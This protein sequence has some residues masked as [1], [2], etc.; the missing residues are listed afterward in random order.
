LRRYEVQERL[1][2]LAKK[3]GIELTF[4]HGKGGTVGRGGNPATFE[5]I[6]AH[7]PATINGRFRVTEQGEMITQNFGQA[8][9][10]ERTLDLYTAALLAEKHHNKQEVGQEWRGL[11]DKMSDIS[12]AAYVRAKR[13]GAS[14][15]STRRA[16]R[17]QRERSERNASE[18][19]TKKMPN[20]RRK[21][22]STKKMPICGGR[23]STLPRF[24]PRRT[25]RTFEP[26]PTLRLRSHRS[27]RYRKIVREDERFVPYFRAATPELELTN[28]NIGSRPAK[29]KVG[30]GVES[31]RAIPWNFAWT[32]TRCNLPSWLGAGEAIAE[33]RG[34]ERAERAKRGSGAKGTGWGRRKRTARRS[35]GVDA[36]RAGW[37]RRKRTGAGAPHLGAGNDAAGAPPVL[38]FVAFAPL[39]PPPPLPC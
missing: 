15:A 12:C 6:L 37:G 36:K 34:S 19:S 18:A 38:S 35:E 17:A 26:T 39:A 3:E 31:L 5:A 29:R 2:A 13:A 1:A 4:F 9:I 11:M 23:G 25:T 28:L 30:G 10:A 21:R 16:K 33:V 27:R 7:P 24:R 20:L 22:A 14:E 32:Q 8:E